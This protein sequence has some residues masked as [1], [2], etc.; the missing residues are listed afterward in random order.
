M[1][2]TALPVGHIVEVRV[3]EDA[4]RLQFGT[5]RCSDEWRSGRLTQVGLVLRADAAGRGWWCDIRNGQSTLLRPED[6]VSVFDCGAA[7]DADLALSHD[8]E[9]AL[10][11]G[12]RARAEREP[13]TRT[14]ATT[15]G[16]L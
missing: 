1:S 13:A 8:L 15:G 11:A 2:D 5:D 6:I 14:V 12:E 9:A 10:A 16:L 4:A 7:V 3:T